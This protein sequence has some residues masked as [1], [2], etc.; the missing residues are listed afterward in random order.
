MTSCA[1]CDGTMAF[2]SNKPRDIMAHL[3]WAS[4]VSSYVD[5][6]SYLY[7]CLSSQDVVA[8]NNNSHA[9]ANN[10]LTVYIVPA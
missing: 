7:L 3:V 2:F 5:I 4:A 1:C 6:F 10:A 9:S 8:L